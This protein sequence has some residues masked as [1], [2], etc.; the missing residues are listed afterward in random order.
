MPRCLKNSVG[1]DFA[2]YLIR[3]GVR[4]FTLP[5][6]VKYNNNQREIL[7]QNQ[8]LDELNLSELS[9]ADMQAIATQLNTIEPGQGSLSGFFDDFLSVVN[10]DALGSEALVVGFSFVALLGVYAFRRLA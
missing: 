1:T 4:N 10:I 3:L 7:M 6:L 8:K 9:E 5:I 2:I